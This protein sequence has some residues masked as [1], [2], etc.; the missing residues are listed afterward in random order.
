MSEKKMKQI[1]C[2]YCCKRYTEPEHFAMCFRSESDKEIE[3]D[4]AL[5]KYNMEFENMSETEAESAARKRKVVTINFA[6]DPPEA[7]GFDKKQYEE[8]GILKTVRYHGEQLWRRL[9]PHCH[10][11][12]VQDAGFIE[13]KMIGMYG[14]TSVGKTVYLTMLE[15]ILKRDPLLGEA[16]NSGFYGTLQYMGSSEEKEAHQKQYDG[17]IEDHV[18]YDATQGQKR[19]KPQSFRFSYKAAKTDNN[20]VDKQVILTFC[21]IPGE[22][23]RDPEK[24]RRTGFYLQN[25]DGIFLL[26][27]P[28]RFSGVLPY[29]KGTLNDPKENV[30]LE[31]VESLGQL[32]DFLRESNAGKKS[33]IPAAVMITKMD[34]LKQLRNYDAVKKYMD[35]IFV[36]DANRLHEKFLNR[37]IIAELNTAVRN[38]VSRLGGEML[39]TAVG[40]FLDV[41]SYFAVSAIGKTPVEA[42]IE[43]E[44]H[45]QL[46]LKTVKKVAGAFEP[47]RVTEPFYWL[48][49]Q[50]DCIP[51]HYR[52]VWM[53][54]KKKLFGRVEERRET[55]QF[56]YYESERNGAAKARLLKK[57]EERKIDAMD[58]HWKRIELEN[59]L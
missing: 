56:Y 7:D 13:M 20:S 48:M 17:L 33:R 19:V 2:P 35:T 52:E 4:A 49:A 27:D 26:F 30:R 41:N 54:T 29:V 32:A 39:C 16:A 8:Y 11:D 3:V 45:G 22:D 42:K 57:R 38:M 25:V 23:T 36:D 9:C 10:N 37:K 51:Y 15:A 12:L 14:D 6:N 31:A 40:N 59:A 58:D 53:Y 55:V 43:V 5:K 47:F 46:E 24:L 44:N 34:A 28:T 18:L 50:F 1:I 21:D